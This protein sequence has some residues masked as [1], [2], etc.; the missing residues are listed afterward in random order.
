MV[1]GRAGGAAE[2]L[3]SRALWND[4]HVGLDLKAVLDT[5]LA[6]STDDESPAPDVWARNHHETI[7]VS[8]QKERLP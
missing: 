4:L 5:L 7:G 8:R 1:S 2:T 3:T 6:G